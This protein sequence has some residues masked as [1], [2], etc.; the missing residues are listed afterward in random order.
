MSRG[1]LV[2]LALGFTVTS[3]IVFFLGMLV[4]QGIEERKLLQKGSNEPVMKIPLGTSP[5]GAR[6]SARSQDQQEM[7]FYETLSKSPQ[8]AKKK[9]R[10]KKQVVAP[11][12]KLSKAETPARSAE[13]K[14]PT[15]VKG[16]RRGASLSAKRRAVVWSVQVKA[17]TR[18]GD[19]QILANRLKGKG[20]DAYMVAG[21]AVT[22]NSLRAPTCAGLPSPDR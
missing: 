15:K 8:P 4:G 3:S 7:T 16:V 18:R 2:I 12:K 19:A 1:Q 22:A 10:K 13:K 6:L 17:F 21:P 11:V 5:K 20:Y 14:K 9:V